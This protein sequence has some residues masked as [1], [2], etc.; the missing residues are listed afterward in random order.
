MTR[1]TVADALDRAAEALAQAAHELRGSE[2][3]ARADV[4]ASVPTRQAA[5][6]AGGPPPSVGAPTNCPKHGTPFTP[7]KTPGWASYCSQTTDDPAWGKPKTDRD[8]N[9][10]L[11]CRITDRNAHEWLAV[12]GQAA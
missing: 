12:H 2:P 5:A 10:V 3:S 9:P 8:G 6:P 4:P 7:S 1:E 11:Y